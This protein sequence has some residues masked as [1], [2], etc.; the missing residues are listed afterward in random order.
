MCIH[1]EKC[2]FQTVNPFSGHFKPFI[3]PLNL[4]FLI[5]LYSPSIAIKNRKGDRGSPCLSPLHDWKT[6]AGEPLNRTKE[7]MVEIHRSIHFN[8]FCP[9]PIHF[10]YLHKVIRLIS[11]CLATENA[12]FL[13][14]NSG[15][16]SFIGNQDRI[17]NLSP[18]NECHLMRIT[19]LLITPF[20]FS[21]SILESNL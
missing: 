16:N 14:L 3:Q 11:L 20:S 10:W 5:M 12:W 15:I 6:P 17:Y 8:N 1:I 4:A 9:K 18:F 2:H 7:L 19:K 13:L 21:V